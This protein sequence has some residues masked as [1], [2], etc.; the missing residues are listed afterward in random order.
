MNKLGHWRL[1][2]GLTLPP[3]FQDNPPLGFIYKVTDKVNKKWYFGQKKM[4]TTV[5][6]PPLKGKVRKRK[7]IKQTDWK[8][9]TTSCNTLKFE[10]SQRPKQEFDFEIL[11][12]VDSKWMMDYIE[13]WY[14]IHY[15]AMFVENSYN[16]IVNVRLSKFDSMREKWSSVKQE[17]QYLY[18]I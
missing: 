1:R 13:L 18:Q 14:Q 9:Y 8:T 5:S 4:I 15:D 2:E 7:V 16:S 10:I 11:H 12:F 17:L 3:D 6:R